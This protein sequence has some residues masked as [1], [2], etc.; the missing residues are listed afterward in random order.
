MAA[1]TTASVGR[2]A[3]AVVAVVAVLLV[4]VLPVDSPGWVAVSLGTDLVAVLV[5][6][7]A[8]IRMPARA[9]SVWWPLW[10]YA[11]LTA[12]ADVTYDVLQYHF[13]I[14]PFPSVAD[15]LYFAAYVPLIVALVKLMRQ[16]QRVWDRP[17]WID[18]AVILSPRSRSRP[19]SC[20]CRWPRSP[21]PPT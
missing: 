17:A 6:L 19:C 13:G 4:A 16:R 14:T 9:R 10:L 12:A 5:F 11:A 3:G 20:C 8:A 15:L 7:V 1:Q 2:R 21:R 18:S